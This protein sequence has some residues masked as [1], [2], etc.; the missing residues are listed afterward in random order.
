MSVVLVVMFMVP[1]LNIA[2]PFFVAVL[3]VNVQLFTVYIPPFLVIVILP[4][5]TEL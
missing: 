5:V 2:P 1:P 3:P 4:S